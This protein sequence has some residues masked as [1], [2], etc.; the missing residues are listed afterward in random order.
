VIA[1]PDI[2]PLAHERLAD[3]AISGEHKFRLMQVLGEIGDPS[4][5]EPMIDAV[6]GNTGNRAVLR[7]GLRALGLMPPSR[8]G[9]E[10][11]Q[12]LLDGDYSADARQ[13][14]LIYLASVRDQRAAAIAEEYSA[15][16]VEPGVRVA[17]L[18]LA[19]R[20]GQTEVKTSIVE[21]LDT[22]EDRSQ[23]EVL[24]RALG[25]LTTPD[26]LQAVASQLP[27]HR[28]RPYFREVSLLVEFRHAE[29]DRRVELAR[30]LIE[31]G[32]PWDRREAVASLVEHGP[33]G[34]LIEYLQ[35]HPAMGLPLERSV[36]YSSAGVP[37]LAQIRRMGYGIRE[38]PEGFE[39]VREH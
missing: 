16:T 18:L 24:I 39:L 33:T 9:F 31:E 14:A 4:S 28:D 21:L 11:A 37:I 36:V 13:G 15:A 30:R 25:E 22:T 1:G 12:E 23:G 20:L 38:T 17:A 7:S 27:L 35:L 2:L 5:V 19:A 6:R 10:F 3:P 26:E 8:A 32:H 29:G 34:V